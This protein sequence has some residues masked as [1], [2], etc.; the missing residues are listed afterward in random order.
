[1]SFELIRIDKVKGYNSSRSHCSQRLQG[2]HGT[3]PTCNA[4]G[5]AFGRPMPAGGG[6][7]AQ[8]M[9]TPR[10]YGQSGHLDELT[11]GSLMVETRRFFREDDD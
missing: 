3:G 7:R 5:P 1:M 10:G 8:R 6:Q 11:A 4:H 2:L 9:V